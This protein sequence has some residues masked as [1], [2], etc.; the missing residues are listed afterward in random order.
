[1]DK[2]EETLPEKSK[3]PVYNGKDGQDY[4]DQIFVKFPTEEVHG[5]MRFTMGKYINRLGEKD[6]RVKEVKKIID[7]ANRYL[8]YLLTHK[9]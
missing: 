8:E 6:D 9:N 2:I 3:N 1:M 5:A 4:L 7:Y